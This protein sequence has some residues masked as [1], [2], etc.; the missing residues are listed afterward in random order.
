MDRSLN[1]LK[2]HPLNQKIY[3]D[4]ECSKL[5]ESIKNSGVLVPLSVKQDGTII[6]GHR[7][8]KAA[9]AIGLE[10]VPVVIVEF[11]DNLAE[12]Q[13]IIEHN[14][15]REK[16]LSQKMREAEEIEALEAKLAERRRLAN[17]KQGDKTPEVPTLAQRET[18][19]TRKDDCTF[20]N[21]GA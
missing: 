21:K 2:E 16:T 18:G 4:S 6:S 1:S 19:K 20:E 11:T 17:L 13:A 10:S 8:F 14:R 7:R 12:K 3:G 9:K 15:Q 5:I